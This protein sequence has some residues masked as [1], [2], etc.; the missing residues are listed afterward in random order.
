MIQS[1]Q[2]RQ[3]TEAA[4]AISRD[5]GADRSGVVLS[6]LSRAGADLAVS[7]TLLCPPAPDNVSGPVPL[8]PAVPGLGRHRLPLPIRAA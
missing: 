7:W 4:Y 5:L 2:A 3:V 6:V 1:V 8:D